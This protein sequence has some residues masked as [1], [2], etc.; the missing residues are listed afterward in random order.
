MDW[1]NLTHFSISDVGGAGVITFHAS[2]NPTVTNY[3]LRSDG[4]NT[5]YNA[6]LGGSLFFRINNGNVMTLGTDGKVT[7]AF[8]GSGL[9]YASS[10]TLNSLANG[11]ANQLLGMNNAGTS[12]E[13]KTVNGSLTTGITVATGIGNLTLSAD[14]LTLQTVANFFPKGDTRYLK[15]S[16]PLSWDKLTGKPTT[17][18][19]YGITD[20]TSLAGAQTLT[21][22]TLTAP[23]I[24]A[25]LGLVKADVGLAN[26]D[27]TSDLNKPVSTAQSAALALKASDA[28]VVHLTGNE[29]IAGI[30]TFADKV[31]FGTATVPSG[32]QFAFNGNAIA[33]SLTV[34]LQSNWG[35]YIFADDYKLAP[36]S[37]VAKYISRYHHLPGIPDAGQVARQGIDLGEMNTELVKKVEELTLYLL[38]KEKQLKAQQDV[39]NAQEERL[40]RIEKKLQLDPNN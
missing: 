25:P 17:L 3:F 14:T 2:A 28:N 7:F 20:A 39:I 8:L 24:T 21:N 1:D 36:L 38:E 35:D 23:V 9:T 12:Y 33:T 30:K 32:Y 13:Y 6:A 18:S 22:K 34:K 26:A 5:V 16:S 19:G 27:N 15:A 4:T 29:N 37:D 40:K 10:G 31:G 11:T